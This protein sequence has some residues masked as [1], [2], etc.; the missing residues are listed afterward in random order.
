MWEALAVFLISLC[1]LCCLKNPR[2]PGRP[3]DVAVSNNGNSNNDNRSTSSPEPQTP[4]REWLFSD[5]EE[6]L[7]AD[8]ETQ[9][10]VDVGRHVIGSADTPMP[11]T[12]SYT[13]SELSDDGSNSQGDHLPATN[14]FVNTPVL[15]TA[16]RDSGSND[17]GIMYFKLDTLITNIQ[18]DTELCELVPSPPVNPLILTE[19]LC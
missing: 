1:F 4:Q 7:Q 15:R 11:Q 5:D 10:Q 6:D 17:Q 14:R 19:E 13:D 16:H 9:L 12:P 8:S 18:A 2:S 3:A